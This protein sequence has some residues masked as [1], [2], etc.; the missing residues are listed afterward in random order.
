MIKIN[1]AM[2]SKTGNL[3]WRKAGEAS[4]WRK[5]AE[6]AGRANTALWNIAPEGLLPVLTATIIHKGPSVDV[7]Q[8]CYGLCD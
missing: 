5:S 2:C 7:A 3:S 1:Q 8:V 6:G 4:Q